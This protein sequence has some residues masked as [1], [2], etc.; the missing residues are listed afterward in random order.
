M[1]MTVL[2]HDIDQRFMAT[3]TPQNTWSVGKPVYDLEYADDT[4]LMAVSIPQLQAFLR[5]VQVEATLYGLELNT[6]KT[7]LLVAPGDTRIISFANGDPV[8]G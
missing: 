3:G 5:S 2:F 1:L 7:E 4:A 6:R 8:L